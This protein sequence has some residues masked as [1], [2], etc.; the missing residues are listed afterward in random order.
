M[1]YEMRLTEIVTHFVVLVDG[2]DACCTQGGSIDIRRHAREY[3]R[4]DAGGG[5][6][7]D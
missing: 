3:H 1:N 5:P 2:V 4:K 7:Q 6:K